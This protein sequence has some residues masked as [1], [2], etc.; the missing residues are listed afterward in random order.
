MPLRR[1][2]VTLVLLS[3][4]CGDDSSAGQPPASTSG[5]TTQT[6]SSG[7]DP[8]DTGIDPT[9]SGA[10]TI[11]TTGL[12]SSSDGP[13]SATED[14][15]G[16][17]AGDC[18]QA[19]LC[20]DFEAHAAGAPPMAP[21]MVQ[22]VQATVRVDETRA[23]SGARSVRVTTERGGGSFRRGY[24]SVEGAPVFPLDGN[25]M[26]GRAMMWL[27]QTPAGSVH[28]THIQGEGEVEGMGFRALS[29][30]GGQ[31]M[32]RLMAN[33]E[34]QGV[35]TDC[36]DHSD[37]VFPTGTW[38]CFEWRFNGPNDEMNLWVDGVALDDVT[39]IGMGEGCGGNDTGGHWYS[40]LYDT[41][42]LGWEHYQMSDVAHDLWI[43]DVAI[44]TDRI[45]CPAL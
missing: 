28:W 34:T 40:P 35:S 45:G 10:T 12:D 39:V 19:L 3:L 44:D 21:W 11:T 14:D 22:E 1:S 20:D 5:S 33:Y 13:T 29:R 15:T 6:Q 23:F 24:M 32:G 42:R 25:V 2:L 17:M 7:D 27:D 9:T 16:P 37:T 31:H 38:V 43:D 26:W 30:Y 8:S 4:A 18:S 41:L 36:W